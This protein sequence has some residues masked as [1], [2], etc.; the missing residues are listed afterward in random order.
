[1]MQEDIQSL[2]IKCSGQLTKVSGNP[3]VGI[4]MWPVKT[5]IR[6]NTV[7]YYHCN[8]CG[9]DYLPKEALQAISKKIEEL[10]GIP[11]SR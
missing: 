8:S 7:E 6:V 11:P 2:C 9:V 4:Q 10:G 5:E 1:M 3:V